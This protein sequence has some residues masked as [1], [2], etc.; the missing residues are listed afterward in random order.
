[1]PWLGSPKQQPHDLGGAVSFLC[2]DVRTTAKKQSKRC[3][4]G[5]M[6]ARR[7][8]WMASFAFFPLLVLVL[9]LCVDDL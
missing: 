6:T 2:A 4:Y 3:E 9:M 1:M 8:W 5:T 7:G